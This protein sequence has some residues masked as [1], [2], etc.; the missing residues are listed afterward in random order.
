MRTFSIITVLLAVALSGCAAGRQ[1]VISRLRTDNPR[2]QTATIAEVVRS[3][4][5]TMAGELI[6][7]LDSPDDGV[8]FMAAAGL[9]RLTGRE[10]DRRIANPDKRP[11]IVAAWRQW[12]EHEGRAAVSAP[13]STKEA[14]KP[15]DAAA[16]ATSAG[17]GAANS[18]PRSE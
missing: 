11:A 12:W 7:L 10:V 5:K 16:Q 18:A 17:T 3:G 9:H 8:R 4:D 1:D 15:K 2:V 13:A 6:D 14:Q